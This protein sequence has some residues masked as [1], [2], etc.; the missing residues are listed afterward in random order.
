MNNSTVELEK[1]LTIAPSEGV[2]VN[3]ARHILKRSRETYYKKNSDYGNAFMD[4]YTKYGVV[5]FVVRLEDKFSRLRSLIDINDM[6]VYHADNLKIDLLDE[7]RQVADE[8]IED[9]LG[10]IVNY[11]IMYVMAVNSIKYDDAMY[12]S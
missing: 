5:S 12:I 7:E 11:L 6:T 9:T 2:R 10:D 1:L 8:T 3:M 4:T